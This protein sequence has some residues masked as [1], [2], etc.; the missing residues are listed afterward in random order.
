[1]N[2]RGFDLAQ[3]RSIAVAAA[4]SVSP[5]AERV[6]LSQSSVSEQLKTLEVRI[7][8]PLFVRNKHDMRHGGGREA[9]QSRA[10]RRRAVRRRV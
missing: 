4:G 9:V 5:G 10:P 1:M 6:F 3:L 7:G 8:H 2:A